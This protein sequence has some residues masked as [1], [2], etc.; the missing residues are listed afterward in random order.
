MARKVTPAQLKRMVRQAEQK[1]KSAINKYNSE[2]RKLQ[3]NINSYNRE[4]ATYNSRVR[5]HNSRLR[6]EMRRLQRAHSTSRYVAVQ[7]STYALHEAFDEVDLAV[8]RGDLTSEGLDI[9]DLAE[10]ET[11]NSAAV[12]NALLDERDLPVDSTNFRTTAITNELSGISD[13]LDSR[14]RGALFALNPENPDAARHFCTSAREVLVMLLEFAAPNKT[15]L[16]EFPNCKKTDAGQPTRR[17]KISYLLARKGVDEASLAAFIDT[18]INDVLTLFRTFNEGTHGS[19]GKFGIGQLGSIK[20]RVEG[21]IR[22]IH[23]IIAL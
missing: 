2:V 20:E 3:R 13:E 15:I 10:G 12:A 9:A 6:A 22:F 4:V 21:A 8:E 7:S 1:Q 5:S 14:W 19:A 16:A 17:E 11:A 18:D 23:H